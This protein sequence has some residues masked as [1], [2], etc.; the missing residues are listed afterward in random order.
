MVLYKAEP[1]N[2]YKLLL[3][4]AYTWAGADVGFVCLQ[5]FSKLGYRDITN[6]ATVPTIG[7]I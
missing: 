1:Y 6:I 5:S 7:K 4:L 3:S 2:I